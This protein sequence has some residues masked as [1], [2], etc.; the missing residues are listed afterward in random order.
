MGCKF[1]SPALRLFNPA[2]TDDNRPAF[3]AMFHLQKITSLDLPELAPYHTAN[4]S[5]RFIRP[6]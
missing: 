4:P 5:R 6:P 2:R 3:A 1:S